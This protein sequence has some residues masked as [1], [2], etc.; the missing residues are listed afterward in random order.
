MPISST[1]S[2]IATF[3][4]HGLLLATL[5]TAGCSGA[6]AQEEA[7]TPV[8][9]P[10]QT[11]AMWVW[12]TSARLG[13]SDGTSSLLAS[14]QQAGVT[15]VYLSIGSVIEDAR[16]PAMVAALHDAGIR[17]EALTGEANWYQAEHRDAMLAVID[18][19]A[20]YN[21][22]VAASARFQGMHL[23]IEPHQLAENKANHAFLPAL[24]ETLDQARQRAATQNLDTAADLPRFALQENGAAFARAVPRIVVMLYELRDK[25]VTALAEASGKIVDDTYAAETAANTGRMVIGLSVDDYSVDLET[26]LGAVESANTTDARRSR[27]GGW[28][29]HDEARYRARFQR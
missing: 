10:T 2:R 22:K 19:V 13:T 12:K 5:A 1:F 25:S 7:A 4:R 24:A 29:I 6:R 15:E 23:D 17:V 20:A 28:A 26:M 11:R 9:T 27:Y 21:A 16:L 18:S 3:A 8:S 14:C